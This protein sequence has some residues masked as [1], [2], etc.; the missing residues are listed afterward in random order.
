MNGAWI[1]TLTV[2]TGLLAPPSPATTASPS[3][4]VEGGAAP[5]RLA[6]PFWPATAG[7]PGGPA[8]GFSAGRGFGPAFGAA[9]GRSAGA[10]FGA[11]L[12]RS[13]GAVFGEASGARVARWPGER[14]RSGAL[15]CAVSTPSGRPLTFVPR[16]GLTTRRISAR[17]YL[18]FTGC[19]SPDGSATFLR[20]GWVNVKATA[21]ASCATAHR[22]RGT[23]R[24]T[25]FGAT[26]RPAGTSKL[27]IKADR[28]VA[29]HPADTLLTGTVRT[30]WLAGRRAR[31]GI[32]PPTAILGCAASGLHAYPGHGTITFD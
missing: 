24:I 5:F 9:A 20:S 6:A 16:V 31:G 7:A 22:V 17:G 18:E 8:F 13:L 11:A 2:A 19:T 29:R 10:D 28:L 23:A 12:G 25:W 1:I 27:G 4:S 15:T 26:G 14:A 3:G 30:G 32:A 21:Q